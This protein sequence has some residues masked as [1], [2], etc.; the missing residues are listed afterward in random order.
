MATTRSS[1]LDR[2]ERI[3]MGRKLLGTTSVEGDIV[4]AVGKNISIPK[5]L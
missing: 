2:K 4:H 5:I 3:K 1:I